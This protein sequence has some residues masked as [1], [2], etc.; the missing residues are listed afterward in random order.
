MHVF[1][2]SSGM[3]ESAPLPEQKEKSEGSSKKQS[4]KEEHIGW[5]IDCGR[6]C[7]NN[8]NFDHVAVMH[9]CVYMRKIHTSLYQT[10]YELTC[11]WIMAKIMKYAPSQQK[12]GVGVYFI[13]LS[14][15]SISLLSHTILLHFPIQSWAIM[16]QETI[17]G[18]CN[19]TLLWSSKL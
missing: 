6:V 19:V 11:G 5:K 4:N 18:M 3:F 8:W 13:I 15:F 7:V 2:F 1:C 17:Q 10:K 16:L 12:K 14:F 9:E